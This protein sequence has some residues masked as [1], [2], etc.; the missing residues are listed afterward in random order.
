MPFSR[1]T[2]RLIEH[3]KSPSGNAKEL[4]DYASMMGAGM[5]YEK[6]SK[7]ANGIYTIIEYTRPDNTLYMR[8]TLS[9]PVNG[10]YTKVKK[11]YFQ[12][13][14]TTLIT[15]DEYALSYDADGIEYKAVKL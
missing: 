10:N 3:L 1:I 6:K 11:E 4:F 13:N 15:S 14:G 9:L 5:N 7:D 8:S 12:K 2:A